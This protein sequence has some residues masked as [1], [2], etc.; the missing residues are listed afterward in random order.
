MPPPSSKNSKSAHKRQADVAP[1]A[2]PTK[3]SRPAATPSKPRQQG[4]VIDS[5]ETP[6]IRRLF[7]P[8]AP[9]SIG[10]TPQRDGRVLGLFDLL[11][12]KDESTPSR[13]RH[14][15]DAQSNAHIHATP[16]KRTRAE[17]EFGSP[18]KLASTP[19]STTKRA[20]VSTFMT[21]LKNRNPNAQGSKTPGSVSK[22]QFSTPAFLRRAPLPPMDE[23]GH[24]VSPQPIRL[25][26]KPLVRGLSSVVASLRKMEEEQLDDD[27]DALREMEDEAAGPIPAKKATGPVEKTVGPAEKPKVGDMH[28]ADSQRPVLLGGF[29]DEAQFDSDPEQQLDR[30]GQPLRVYKKKGQKRTTKKV[31]M[32]PTRAKRPQQAPEDAQTSGDEHDGDV[33]HET[34]L[35][36]RTADDREQLDLESGSDFAASDC[37]EGGTKKKARATK[38]TQ[39]PAKDAEHENPIKKAAR[40][41]NALAHANFK[42]LKLRNSGAKGGPGFGSRFR[43]RR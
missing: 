30:N 13:S 4:D 28:V 33:V 15:D 39:A 26:R 38:K 19:Q 27:L 14:G 21:P 25:P 24:Y 3:R 32:R 16:S 37:E 5:F 8:A 17:M 23:N 12:E 40:K 43:R 20:K 41:V 42:R 9:T 34:Q 7:S 36:L 22:L 2:S 29:D 10:P 1:S 6:T 31:N 18:V 11:D 35:A